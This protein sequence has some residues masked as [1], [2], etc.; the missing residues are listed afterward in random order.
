MV[1]LSI[2]VNS[3]TWLLSRSLLF[4]LLVF[5]GL[6]IGIL[7]GLFQGFYG[8]DRDPE[9][10]VTALTGEWAKAEDRVGSGPGI[11]ADEQTMARLFARASDGYNASQLAELATGLMKLSTNDLLDLAERVL[12][13][14]DPMRGKMALS[15]NLAAVLAR[16][17]PREGA[18][19]F[20]DA[21][22]PGH[23]PPAA[24]VLLRAWGKRQGS[25][26]ITWLDREAPGSGPWE[27]AILEGMV[28]S[29]QSLAVSRLLKLSPALTS[30]FAEA[31]ECPVYLERTLNRV[32]EVPPSKAREGLLA[33]LA[34]RWGILG[35]WEEGASV[36]GSLPFENSRCEAAALRLTLAP[37][38]DQENPPENFR[39][40]IDWFCQQNASPS[41][42]GQL[43]RKWAR[44]SPDDTADWL[45][46][47]R[48]GLGRDLGMAAL[49]SHYRV[50]D[51]DRA[52]SIAEA[53]EEDG[54]RVQTLSRLRP[55]PG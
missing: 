4:R 25:D 43:A 52:L 31:F 15:G 20:C 33:D 45:V 16:K 40:R 27:V 30:R 23:S 28:A 49:A 48:A 9:G 6:A 26:A 36:L 21:S 35:R 22:R 32:A 13:S 50:S 7:G 41:S 19:L 12:G 18:R 55:F 38:L 46:S 29:G 17:A 37:M 39:D 14:D 34:C 47:M 11:K 44:I 10:A 8:G 51:R 54:L 1:D 53:I 2:V 42:I 5:P 3:V 24:A